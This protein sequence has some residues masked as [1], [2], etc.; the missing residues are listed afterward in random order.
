MAQKLNL[1]VSPYFDDFDGNKNYYKVL[2]KPG[3]PVQARELTTQQSILQNQIEQ[4]GNHIFKDGS[5][6][7]PGNLKYE[8]PVYAVEIEPTFNGSPI[9]L[10]FDNLNGKRIRGQ[11]SNVSAEI[12]YILTNTESERG[13][14]T[15]YVKFLESGGENFD[16]KT[17]LDSETLILEQ[18]VEFQNTTLQIG[19]G[20]CNTVSANCISLGSYIS[21]FS[22][23]YFVRGIFARVE[24]QDLLLD[25]YGIE[26]SYKVGFE[27]EEKIV[28]SFEDDSLNDNAQGF[29]NYAA[30]GADRFQLN[31]ALTKKLIDDIE[32]DNF[33][34]I[35]RVNFGI[36]T[37]SSSE[38]SQYNLI[39]DELARRTFDESGDY[40]VS[41][42][43]VFVRETLN[44]RYSIN[45]LY[46]PN[47]ITSNGNIPSE[48]LM[49][50]Q[51][52]PGKAYVKGY[53]VESISSR[54]I[55]VPK[56][57][58]TAKV[59][60]VS[61]NFSAGT[62]FVLNNSYG[63]AP[64]GLGTTVVVD[65]MSSRIGSD[66][67]VSSG[68]TIGQARIYDYV[69]ESS[70]QNDTSRMHLRLFD[71][72]TYT[73]IGLSTTNTLTT[74]THIKGKTSNATGF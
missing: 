74:P 31:L 63:S 67:A 52:G 2:F 4:F 5:V 9:S 14:Y 49:T 7:I 23:V 40:V 59:D 43:S 42:F 73:T 70:Y 27:I 65:L 6:V 39:R 19:Q 38:N 17:F 18:P 20:F 25:Q 50:Y 12:F 62:L 10:Y 1:N 21:L 45:G 66:P 16:I 11:S 46:Y 44:N 22:G 64:V 29:S 15:L 51:I 37:Y 30:P 33:V 61:V 56:P 3:Y 26:P 47:Q 58:T 48:D 28:N 71:I 57:R 36:P 32:T 24:S 55:D 53:D 68:T 35:F 34:E 60:N 13:N 69:P 41:P 54:L 72:N 8:N